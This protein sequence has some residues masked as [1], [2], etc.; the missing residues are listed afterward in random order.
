M[1]RDTKRPRF[2][3]FRRAKQVLRDNQVTHSKLDQVQEELV[4]T[5][6]EREEIS[7]KLDVVTDMIIDLAMKT[8]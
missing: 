2:P 7:S 8:N 5:K 3:T 4:E 1:M 6:A